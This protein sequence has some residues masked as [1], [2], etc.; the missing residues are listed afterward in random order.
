[1][2]AEGEEVKRSS[3][4]K[5]FIA[6]K[7]DLAR[8]PE[9]LDRRQRG[10]MTKKLTASMAVPAEDRWYLSKAAGRALVLKRTSLHH[11]GELRRGQTLSDVSPVWTLLI[12]NPC[13]DM[14][15]QRESLLRLSSFQLEAKG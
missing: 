10:I 1:M 14:G 12:G 6:K 9:D 7:R 5:I 8:Q 2:V 4:R 15:C 3:G 13:L 11:R